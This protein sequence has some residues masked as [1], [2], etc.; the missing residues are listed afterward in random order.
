[1]CQYQKFFKGS[2]SRGIGWVRLHLLD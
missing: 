2:I 1:M